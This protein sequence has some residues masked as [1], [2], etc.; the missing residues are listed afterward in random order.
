MADFRGVQI[1][2]G[3]NSE[4]GSSFMGGIKSGQEYASAKALILYRQ[5][6]MQ[7]QQVQ[8]QQAQVEHQKQVGQ[9]AWSQLNDV[10]N[11]HNPKSRMVRYQWFRRSM[12]Q[13][14]IPVSDDLED[15]VKNDSFRSDL[16]GS[17]YEINKSKDPKVIA[18]AQAQLIQILPKE[19]PAMLRTMTASK[20][21]AQRNNQFEQTRADKKD[22]AEEKADA[23][24]D[25][26]NSALLKDYQ[27][28]IS[29]DANYKKADQQESD[30]ESART[31]IKDAAN[32]NAVDSNLAKVMLAKLIVPGRIN[33]TE[34][35]NAGGSKA[36]TAKISQALSEMYDGTLTEENAK[37][38]NGFVDSIQNQ[39]K[40]H[41]AQIGQSYAKQFV[42]LP[43]NEG[44][45]LNDSYEKLTG[46]KLTSSKSN[47]VTPEQLQDIKTKMDALPAGTPKNIIKQGLQKYSSDQ[48]IQLTPEHYKDL[49]LD[50]EEP[51][52]PE[53][54]APAAAPAEAAPQQGD[55]DA[56]SNP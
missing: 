6:E 28:R 22:A 41:K 39:A 37:M 21:L 38:M 40:Q 29:S 1:P 31:I 19:G 45:S 5:A 48:N 33:K 14:G 10:I 13:I 26:T 27:K 23:K 36:V 25:A 47:S 32:G 7:R 51:A 56:G 49:G 55:T 24:A 3:Q 53:A 17:L 50:D 20:A 46:N 9:M 15:L 54:A 12:S 35:D 18:D 43:G 2:Q 4:L 11:D 16:Q 30:A 34:I 8:L 42:Q 44:M 52:A